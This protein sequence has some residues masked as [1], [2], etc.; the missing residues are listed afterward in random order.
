MYVFP[1]RVYSTYISVY[2]PSDFGGHFTRRSARTYRF[3]G[4][5]NWNIGSY[6]TGLLF[7]RRNLYR[8][9]S[10]GR[11]TLTFCR[12]KLKPMYMRRPAAKGIYAA[13]WRSLT[14]YVC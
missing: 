14:C 8:K 6:S 2:T 13:L 5:I 1:I 3:V 12:A 11:K 9:S 4:R 10:L 7:L